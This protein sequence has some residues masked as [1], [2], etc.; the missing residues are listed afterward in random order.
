[1]MGSLR[2]AASSSVPELR[3][4]QKR[5]L[6]TCKSAGSAQLMKV[7]A[8][9]LKKAKYAQLENV[10]TAMGSSP[11]YNITVD[12]TLLNAPVQR[13]QARGTFSRQASHINL[14][15]NGTAWN[16]SDDNAETLLHELLHA[17][18]EGRRLA[19]LNPDR[20]WK[21]TPREDNVQVEIFREEIV[22]NC[23]IYYFK[24]LR[25]QDLA[26][27]MAK[28][29]VSYAQPYNLNAKKELE[30][31][32]ADGSKSSLFEEGMEIYQGM[33]GKTFDGT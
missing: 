13:G 17:H 15:V 11:V 21:S 1:M 32:F 23:I 9:S 7:L 12:H 16:M 24:G 19:K 22:V 3:Y 30:L 25:G 29:A 33:G 26:A 4:V 20:P 31:F 6:V 28:V 2:R 18:F 8:D 27:I 5:H 14:N 10:V